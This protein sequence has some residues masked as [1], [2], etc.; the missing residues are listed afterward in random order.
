MA[1]CSGLPAGSMPR[2][3]GTLRAAAG[4]GGASPAACRNRHGLAERFPGEVGRPHPALFA[5]A[6]VTAVAAAAGQRGGKDL[7][8]AA[9]TEHRHDRAAAGTGAGGVD[10]L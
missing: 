9:P 6:P 5:A 8:A 1:T 7:G 2:G 10:L 4:G 3:T